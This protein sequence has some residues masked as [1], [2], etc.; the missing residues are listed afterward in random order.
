M[1]VALGE[2]LIVVV[3]VA[4]GVMVLLVEMVS[5]ELLVI[6][7]VPDEVADSKA[8]TESLADIDAVADKDKEEL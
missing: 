5:V 6:V 8:V 4:D 2:V 1:T 3:N 7:A